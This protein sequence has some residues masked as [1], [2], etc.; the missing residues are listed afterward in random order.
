VQPLQQPQYVSQ[1]LEVP[2]WAQQLWT[3]HPFVDL[4]SD[5]EKDGGAVN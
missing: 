2:A 1:P 3:P 4:I 5:D